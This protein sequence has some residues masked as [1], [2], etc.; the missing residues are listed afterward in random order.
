MVKE[1]NE[2][3]KPLNTTQNIQSNSLSVSHLEII[4]RDYL[5]KDINDKSAE[6]NMEGKGT[7]EVS[8]CSAF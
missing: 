4:A 3:D 1:K 2:N 6:C 8:L 5:S 7:E